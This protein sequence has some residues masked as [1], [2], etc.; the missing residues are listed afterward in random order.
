M[1]FRRENRSPVTL[2]QMFEHFKA[3][4]NIKP[5]YQYKIIIGTDSMVLGNN[6]RYITAVTLQRIGNGAVIFYNAIVKAKA[7][8]LTRIMHE[9]NYTIEMANQIIIP[10]CLDENLYYP[11]EIHIDVGNRGESH[12]FQSM[13]IGYV[14]GCGF[15]EKVIKIKPDAYGASNIA[16]RYT[17]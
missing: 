9:V 15:D 2:D 5:T 3:F 13:A 8:M 6:T 11:I 14:K 7:P 17:R 12:A 4:I 1:H 16:D 10:K